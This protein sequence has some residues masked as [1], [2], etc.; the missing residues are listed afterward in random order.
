VTVV[1]IFSCIFGSL[2]RKS[3]EIFV[4]A[5]DIIGC[6]WMHR[7]STGRGAFWDR[8]SA[9]AQELPPR[10]RWEKLKCARCVSFDERLLEKM[11]NTHLCNSVVFVWKK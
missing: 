9:W 11:M 10:G 7:L 3:F 6:C 1:T 8:F 5:N 4:A 2:D